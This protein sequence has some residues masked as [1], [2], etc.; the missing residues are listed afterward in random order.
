MTTSHTAQARANANIALIKY[1]GKRSLELNLPAVGSISITLDGLHS[2][3]AVTFADEFTTDQ[4]L[5][6]GE[7]REAMALRVS[8]QLDL[9]RQLAGSEQRARVVSDNNFPTGAGL[10]SSASGFAALTVAAAKALELDLTPRRLSQLARQGS[11]SAARSLFGGF[12]ELFRGDQGGGE[13]CYAEPLMAAAAWP[14]E[15]VIAVTDAAEKSVGST[16][17]MLASAQ[18]PYFEPWV[19]TS[20]ADLQQGRRAI[21]AKDFA[22]LATVAEASCLKMHGLMLATAPGL[23]YWQGATLDCLHAVRALRAAGTGVFFT[24]DAGPQ[25]KAICEPGAAQ[26]VQQVLA[27]VPGVTQTWISSLG[28]GVEVS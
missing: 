27:A 12:V 19:S 10:A 20:D 25:V 16:A 2:T 1:W 26:R 24:V 22:A 21:L 6:N 7:P 17:G 15:V 9:L 8:E 4:F 28:A 23:L 18:S 13:D 11:A 3:T 14:L 5:L